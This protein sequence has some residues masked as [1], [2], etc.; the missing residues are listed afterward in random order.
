M[1]ENSPVFDK[2]AQV[3]NLHSLLYHMAFGQMWFEMNSLSKIL[4]CHSLLGK[5]SSVKW[6]NE[7]TKQSHVWH[8]AKSWHMTN[9]CTPD[10]KN[11]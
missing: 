8:S 4:I 7:L 9:T 6:A 2:I 11:Q 5:T 10:F 3:R 1:K